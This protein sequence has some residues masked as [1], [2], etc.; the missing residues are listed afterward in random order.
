[1]KLKNRGE[2][3]GRRDNYAQNRKNPAK[4]LFFFICQVNAKR[5]RVIRLWLLYFYK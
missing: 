2:N 1:M 5:L 3:G 4:Q